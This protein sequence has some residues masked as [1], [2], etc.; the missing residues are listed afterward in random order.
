MGLG[1]SVSTLL[2]NVFATDG[3]MGIFIALERGGYFI[4]RHYIARFILWTTRRGPWHYTAFLDA[5]A[6]RLLLRKVGGG[7]IFVH[8]KLMEHLAGRGR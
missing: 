4:V 5:A 2:T 7:Y 8:R 3:W 1:F 6:D